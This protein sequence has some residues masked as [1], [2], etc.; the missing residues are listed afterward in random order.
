[1]KMASLFRIGVAALAVLAVSACGEDQTTAD[2]PG[3]SSSATATE[4]TEGSSSESE[5]TDEP[6]D[7]PQWSVEPADG[8]LIKV[9]G[10]GS[11]SSLRAPRGFKKTNSAY[12]AAESAY[13]AKSGM[14][15]IF[16]YT[17]VNTLEA[18]SIEEYA[19]DFNKPG[20]APFGPKP[21][22]MAD[23]ELDSGPVLHMSGPCE[24][25]PDYCDHFLGIS[26]SGEFYTSVT[27][28]FEDGTSPAERQELYDAVVQTWTIEG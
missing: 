14:P 16:L 18:T 28:Q 25:K 20:V 13:E 6:T 2:T 12:D 15:N 24:E 5:P 22:R 19:A 8:V 11:R 4:S 3:S 7:E 1:M 9:S 10:S 21:E 26:P 23:V 17:F 27:F